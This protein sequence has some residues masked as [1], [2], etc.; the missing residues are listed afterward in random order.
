MSHAYAATRFK[1]GH[2]VAIDFPS[3]G[4]MRKNS[5]GR[6]R[7]LTGRLISLAIMASTR[8][9]EDIRGEVILR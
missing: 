3:D 4:V 2:R 7:A 5:E 1:T 8:R 6:I 9:V